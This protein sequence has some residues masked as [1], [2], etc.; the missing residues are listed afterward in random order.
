MHL[1]TFVWSSTFIIKSNPPRTFLSSVHFI[2]YTEIS[3]YMGSFI[4]FFIGFRFISFEGIYWMIKAPFCFY[5]LAVCSFIQCLSLRSVNLLNTITDYICWNRKRP[6]LLRC[7]KDAR[8]KMHEWMYSLT[9]HT[10]HILFFFKCFIQKIF[11]SG[12][13]I[14]AIPAFVSKF[15]FYL[16]LKDEWIC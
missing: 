3:K 16:R 9:T 7:T 1:Y 6:E 10:K 5:S 12:H 13:G 4:F 14:S 15:F 8:W 2:I 11:F